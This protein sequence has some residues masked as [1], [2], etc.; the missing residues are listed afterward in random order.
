MLAVVAATRTGPPGGPAFHR[1][2]RIRV[3]QAF[4][5]TARHN[6]TVSPTIAVYRN[7][8]I[9][10]DYAASYKVIIDGDE[11][12]RIW[13]GQRLRFDV[14]PGE[15]RVVVRRFIGR[16]KELVVAPQS[17][18][19]VELTCT[20]R[21]MAISMLNVILFRLSA[22]LDLHVTTPSE[23]SAYESTRPR[24]PKSDAAEHERA[25]ATPNPLPPGW[26]PDPSGQA[27]L[28]WWDGTQWIR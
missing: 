16:S 3:P 1:D 21:G 5:D 6:L 23:R 24:P 22:Y 28:C 18:E 17:G 4:C 25:M 10:T 12:G 20:G 19:L 9:W 7:P 27:R 8:Y 14:P 26:Y 11:A 13:R 2:R 15:H